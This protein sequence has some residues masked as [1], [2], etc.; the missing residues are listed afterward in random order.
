MTIKKFLAIWEVLRHFKSIFSTT[1]WMLI[2]GVNIVVAL[3]YASNHLHPLIA[4]FYGKMEAN[5][6][7]AID[8]AMIGTKE[9]WAALLSESFLSVGYGIAA[10]AVNT[11][12]VSYL[13]TKIPEEMTRIPFD[14]GD[15]T[16]YIGYAMLI[17][18]VAII[19]HTLFSMLH[20]IYKAYTTLHPE[21]AK[22]PFQRYYKESREKAIAE[23]AALVEVPV[24][25]TA[26]DNSGL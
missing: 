2:P 3:G 9:Y 18:I 7:N 1:L 17:A 12:V 11:Y 14:A 25:T 22:Q 20:S 23:R 15:W 4:R 5:F 13:L 19:S 16:S 6:H 8:D 26:I 10:F 24:R 21:Y